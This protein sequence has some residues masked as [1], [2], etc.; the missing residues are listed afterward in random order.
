MADKTVAFVQ[1]LVDRTNK[2]HVHWARTVDEGV[3][4]ASF[5]GYSVKVAKESQYDPEDQSTSY[6]HV[7]RIYDKDGSL[8]E[9]ILVYQLNKRGWKEAHE[10]VARLYEA[11][12]REAMGV[13]QALDTLLKE[14]EKEDLPF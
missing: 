13:E 4:Q 7:I 3:F 14:L 9:E 10:S 6:Y 1:A 11:A 8:V 12:R 5:P 2:G